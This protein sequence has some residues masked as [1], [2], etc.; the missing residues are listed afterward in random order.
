MSRN[1][2]GPLVKFFALTFA[3]SWASWSA[4]A[5]IDVP[6]LHWFVFGIGVFAPSLVALG[7]SAR[8]ER[9]AGARALLGRVLD[10]DVGARWYLFAA[11]YMASIKLLVALTHRLVT[12]VW[13]RFGSEA[14]YLILAAIPLATPTQAGEEIGWRG[15]ALPRLAERMGLRWAGVLLGAV[16]ASWHL[17]LFFFPGVDT[18]GQSFPVYLLEVTA[19]SV[20]MTWLYAH[21]RGSLLTSVVAWL[22]RWNSWAWNPPDQNSL[23]PPMMMHSAVNQ[24]LGIVPSAVGGATNPFGLSTSPVAWLTLAFLWIGAAFFLVRMP[25]WEAKPPVRDESGSAARAGDPW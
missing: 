12:G 14:W 24:T 10:W 17:P 25:R 5:A 19:L 6:I 22:A 8:A 3:L 16:W 4:A 20:A 1:Q 13:P 15:Y 7:L 21:T 9:E 2:L 11:G 18:T 23:V